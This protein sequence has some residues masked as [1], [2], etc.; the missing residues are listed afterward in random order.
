[1]RRNYS[2]RT[3]KQLFSASGHHCAHP[4]CDARVVELR[5]E[6][7]ELLGEIAHIEALS[8]E[9]PRA[10]SSLTEK[11][12]NSYSNL[13]ILCGH[14]H[15]L[16]DTIDSEYSAET[17]REWKEDAERATHQKLSQGASSVSFAE[18]Q[19]VCEAFID[20]AMA[21]PSTP[22]TAVPPSDK[23]DA[24]HLTDAV[25]MRMVIGLAQAHQVQEY[26]RQQANINSKFP[27]KLR[28]GFVREYER[29]KE[30]GHQGNDLFVA[31]E[32]YGAESASNSSMSPSELF[33]I[34]AAALSVLCHLFEICDVFEAP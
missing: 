20:G 23:M 33:V 13:V 5:D 16:V 2:A 26:I 31:L 24:N 9:G 22:M 28:Y 29:L 10:N 7:P 4:E 14:H 11:E 3:L 8:N 30:E 15:T 18:L 27:E 6:G 25:H 12:R 19:I 1:M 21:T 34:R 32:E 17:L